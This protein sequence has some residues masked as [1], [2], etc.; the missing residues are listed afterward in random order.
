MNTN[1]F[2]VTVL[3]ITTAFAGFY[4]QLREY[5]NPLKESQAKVAFLQ[6]K[7]EEERFKHLLTSYDLADFKSYVGTIL[8]EAIQKKGAGEKSYQLRTLAS[9]VQSGSSESISALKGKT[10]FESG[11]QNFR[12]K[13][14]DE[15]AKA[16]QSLLQNHAYSPNI[17][18]ALFLLVESKFMLKQYED[19]IVYTNKMLDVYPELEL[20]GY[21]ML[22]LGKVYE[23]EDQAE[24]A[25]EVYKTVLQA[26]TNKDLILSAQESLRAVQL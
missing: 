16:F 19:C 15:A 21:A 26:F 18:E 1:L 9:V 2:L 20:T 22:R 5:F 3:T 24:N 25:I 4:V 13:K 6:K 8:P 12:L 11:K 23:L 17:P 14:Y 7:I 10:L